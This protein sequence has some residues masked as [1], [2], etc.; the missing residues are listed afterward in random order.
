V[1]D[2]GKRFGYQ[3]FAISFADL[4]ISIE[5]KKKAAFS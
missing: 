1:V 4:H 5:E 2:N 3:E